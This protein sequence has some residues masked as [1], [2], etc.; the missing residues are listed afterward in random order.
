VTLAERRPLPLGPRGSVLLGLA[1][2]GLVAAL[3]LGLTPAGLVPQEGGLRLTGRFLMGA[4]NPAFDYEGHAPADWDPFWVKV[5]LALARTLAFALTAMSLALLIGLPL[6]MLASDAWWRRGVFRC[7]RLGAIARPLQ[8]S[9]RVWIALMRSVHELLW[10]VIFLAAFGLNTLG[11]VIAIAIP[12]GGTLAKVFSEMLDE[13][14]RNTADALQGIGAPPTS[15]FLFGLFPRALPDLSAYAFYRLECAVRASAV[16]G[17]FGY[18]TLG[19]HLE[20]SFKD[21]HFREVWTYIYVLLGVVL[22]LEVWSAAI[23]RRLVG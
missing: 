12:Y 17:F 5:G 20:L 9:L 21:A 19:Y 3:S 1:L 18:Q 22:V 10:A 2:I 11:A 4:L 15:A 7:G 6:G 23:R 16:L 14:P 8:V 13:T